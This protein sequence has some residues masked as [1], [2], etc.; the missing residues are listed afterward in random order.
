MN[1]G[2]V[3]EH[4]ILSCAHSAIEQNVIDSNPNLPINLT[5][6]MREMVERVL[7]GNVDNEL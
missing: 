3:Q 7:W 4:T 2:N 1:N 5:S 6:Q